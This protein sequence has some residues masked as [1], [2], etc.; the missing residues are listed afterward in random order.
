MLASFALAAMALPEVI[1]A[2]LANPF[3]GDA[4][5]IRAGDVLYASRCADCH[6]ADAKG[7]RGPDLT[8]LWAAGT[9][10]QRV[11]DA[12]RQGIV[13]S[14]M[15]PSAAPDDEIWAVVAYLKS[16]S[17]VPP[18]DSPNGDYARGREVFASMCADCHT[19][20]GSGGTL[21]PDLSNIA[22]VRSREA[23]VQSIRDP[24]ASIE[25]GYRAVTLVTNRGQRIIGVVKSEDA[26]SVQIV[27]QDER[28]QGYLKADLDDLVRD[29]QSLM[30]KFGLA[31]LSQRELDDLLAYIATLRNTVTAGL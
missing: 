6:G 17:T 28:L 3:D 13:D 18:F 25:L 7:E 16:I 2:Q 9:N 14:I 8:L 4:T 12:V 10:D 1:V 15:P 30:P 24:S 19:V 20:A 23:I 29:E 27:D 22:Q 31:D 21:G 11:F 5:A 26:F